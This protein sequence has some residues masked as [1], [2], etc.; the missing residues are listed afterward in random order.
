MP[1]GQAE[2]E[3]DSGDD[4]NLKGGGGGVRNRCNVEKAVDIVVVT[5]TIIKRRRT[6]G[7]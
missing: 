7:E 4:A 5:M 3:V 2:Q 1:M 6:G